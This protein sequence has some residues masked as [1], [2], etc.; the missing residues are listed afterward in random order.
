MAN[1][2][3][4]LTLISCKESFLEVLVCKDLLLFAADSSLMPFLGDP[5][6][7]L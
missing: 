6:V 5:K 2:L 7:S 3:A 4:K 1:R